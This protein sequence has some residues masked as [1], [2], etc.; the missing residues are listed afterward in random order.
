MKYGNHPYLLINDMNLVEKSKNCKFIWNPILKKANQDLISPPIIPDDPDGWLWEI[1]DK[2]KERILRGCIVYKVTEDRR[3]FEAM[4]KQLWCLIDEWPWIEKFHHEE[5]NL[6]ADLRTGI[7]MYTLGLV[8]DWMYN[9]FSAKEKKKLLSAIVDK[10]YPMLKKDIEANAF[11]LTSYGNNWLAVMLGGYAV[12][13][14]AT[15]D[16]CSFSTEIINLAIER[17]KIMATY[18][19][20]DGAWEEGPFYWGGIAFLIM[21]FDIVDSLP[22]STEKLL[23]SDAL[24]KTC[25]FPIYMNM[26]SGGRA[27]FSDALYYQDHNASYLFSVMARTTQ[28]PQY[29]WAFNEFRTVAEESKP[30]LIKV[31]INDFRPVEETYQFLS[32]DTILTTDYPSQWPLFKV[33]Q[34][35]T[36][37][38]I[39]SRSGF[40]RDDDGLVL[41]ANGGTNGTNHHQLDIGQVIMTFNK[42]NFIYDPG[43]GRAFYLDDRTRVN[44]QNYFAKSSMGHNIVTIN[45]A[46][47]IDSPKA[48]G[49]IRNCVSKTD[50]DL[51][52]INMTSAYDN[53]DCGIRMVKRRR[54][55][56]IVEIEDFYNLS[57]ELPVRLAWFYKGDAKIYNGNSVIIKTPDGDC[58]ILIESKLEASIT[59][60]SYSEAGYL[61]RSYKP[62]FPEV[63]KYISINVQP[64]LKH[65]L[66]TTFYFT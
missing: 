25:M 54:G 47:Q 4:K 63:Y 5:V 51:F 15:I 48:K 53:C 38:F 22:K 65:H 13:A 39:A 29:Q 19:G 60:E 10:G 1:L 34:G 20:D 43:Y 58:K 40:G 31:D 44:R 52:E 30:E 45:G 36:Y 32:Y 28:N 23:T 64:G 49:I 2:T 35:D 21:F 8:Y 16:D 7:I 6:E 37:G 14:Y 26:P 33:F 66:K 42:H 17:T 57:E 12:A 18:V 24:N 61:N 27:N 62:I 41:C 11:Y 3:Y 50:M 59:L 46:N 9:D 56:D 55:L